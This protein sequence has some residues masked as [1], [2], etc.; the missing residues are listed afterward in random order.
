MNRRAWATLILLAST[1]CMGGRMCKVRETALPDAKGVLS[2][3]PALLPEMPV[4]ST[5][6][7]RGQSSDQP[8]ANVTP[9]SAVLPPVNGQVAVRIRAHVNGAPILE[10]ELR[11]AMVMRTGELMQVPETRRASYFQELTNRELDR[12]IERELILQEMLQK[13]KDM[14]RPQLM[15]QLKL[16][17]SKEADK[18]LKDIKTATKVQSDAEF[19]TILQQQGLSVDGLRRQTER[20]FMM[21]EYIR[22]MIYPMVQRISLQQVRDYYEEHGDEF[23][24]SD[25]VKWQ[26]LFIDGS[27]FP[28]KAAARQHADSIVLRAKTGEDFAALVKQFD[29]GDSSLRNGEGIGQKRGEIKPAEVENAVFAIKAGEIGPIVDVGFGFHIVK[30]VEREYA[31]LEPF[32]EKCQAKIREK[33]RGQIAEREYKKIVDE[34]K[35][36]ATVVVHTSTNQD[37]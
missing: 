31:G 18:R 35:R 28:T 20:N 16:E 7:T 33:L 11:E 9:V 4:A 2:D 24:V 30:V 5:N 27:Q 14:K 26:D 1:G 36:K 13:I 22:N 12:L 3:A 29:N 21:T 15:E 25:R 32:S 6:S 37:K 10:E 8:T 19:R 23:Q 17:A 34:L